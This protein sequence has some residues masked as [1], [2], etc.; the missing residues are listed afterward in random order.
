MPTYQ[1]HCNECG[2]DFEEFQSMLEQPLEECP[3]CGGK[4]KRLISG[5]AGFLFKGSGFYQ[6]DYRSSQYKKE[7]AA[8]KTSSSSTSRTPDTPSKSS[9]S[10]KDKSP[11]SETG[12]KKTE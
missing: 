7:A 10:S 6:T 1:Y 8:E 4:P 9:N 3:R 5:G 11:S 2:Y 12:K